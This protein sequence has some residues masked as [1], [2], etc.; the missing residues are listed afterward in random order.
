MTENYS[1]KWP[2]TNTVTYPFVDPGEHRFVREDS[3]GNLYFEYLNNL[4]LTGSLIFDNGSYAVTIKENDAAIVDYKIEL[5]ADAPTESGQVLA[6][7]ASDVE[8][9]EF[10]T[11]PVEASNA[12]VT[13]GTEDY[14]YLTPA[15]IKYS[16]NVVI[17]RGMWNATTGAL[18]SGSNNISSVTVNAGGDYEVSFS[19][20]V[21]DVYYQVNATAKINNGTDKRFCITADTFT[22]SDF[23][24]KSYSGSDLPT[25]SGL[26]RIMITIT[27]TL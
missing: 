22:T 20:S 2:T 8:E 19:T 3:S 7:L 21:A 15:N 4:P 17:A 24:I 14:D 26:A 6:T 25:S 5:P 27:G 23:Q 9:F 13:T 12:T 18:D 11:L 1:V 10:L 16:K